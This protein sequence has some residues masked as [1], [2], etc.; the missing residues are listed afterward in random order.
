MLKF[1]IIYTVILISIITGLTSCSDDNIINPVIAVDNS[2]F[3][4]PFTNGSTWNYT[5]RNNA[6]NI[7][8]DSILHYFTEYPL[9][10]NGTVTILY[11]TLIN[12][13]LT[14]CFL[15]EYIAFG[16]QYSNRFYYINNDT[17]LILYASRSNGSGSG[18]LPLATPYKNLQVSDTNI[19]GEVQGNELRIRDTLTSTLKYPMVSGTQWSESYDGIVT[20]KYYERFYN[21][22]FQTEV[23]SAMKVNIER[24]IPFLPRLTAFYNRNGLITV[25]GTIENIMLTTISSPDGAGTYDLWIER[26][27]TSFNIPQE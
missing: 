20:S 26:T 12:S 7:Q 25:S 17:A 15:D 8:P 23:F 16:I 1:K 9:V 21:I 24:N 2:D 5:V 19:P 11:D 10:T 18:F 27:V 22:S 3:R 13:V 14:K 4:F 6:S